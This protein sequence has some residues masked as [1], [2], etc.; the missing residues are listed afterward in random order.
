MTICNIDSLVDIL[1]KLLQS[2]VSD[3]NF[4]SFEETQDIKTIAIVPENILNISL[5][6][7]KV[8]IDFL[9]SNNTE[10]GSIILDMVGKGCYCM[11]CFSFR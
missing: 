6:Q 11:L 7:F 3:Q 2:L 9:L 4:V 5:G 8:A 10:D 1:D